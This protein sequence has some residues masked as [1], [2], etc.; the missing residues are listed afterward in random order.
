MDYNNQ[1][2]DCVLSYLTEEQGFD[3][4]PP[5]IKVLS[6]VGVSEKENKEV[7]HQFISQNFVLLTVLLMPVLLT[8]GAVL[9]AR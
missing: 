1:S 7:K 9:I 4:L 2:A 6:A 3:W 5:F 8:L